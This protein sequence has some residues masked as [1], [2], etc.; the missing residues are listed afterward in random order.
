MMNKLLLTALLM[1]STGSAMADD[2]PYLTFETTDG[3]K[4]S[5]STTSLTITF[6]NG[7]LMAGTKEFTL[8]DLSKM[9]FSTSDE[10]PT[11][12]KEVDT[13]KMDDA[14]EI[15]DLQGRKVSK[16]QM[17]QGIYVVKTKTGFHKVNVQ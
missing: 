10:T 11:D 16:A 4:T 2:Y 3:T 14:T 13:V 12:I 5:V 15:Y 8:T 1:A 6:Q 7:K 9:Y 17:K